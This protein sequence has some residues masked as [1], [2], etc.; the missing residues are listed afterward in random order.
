[1]ILAVDTATRWTGL[2]L[3]SG[4][5]VV[6]EHCWQSVNTQTVE[7]APAVQ[8]MLR[9]AG[10]AVDDLK[11]VA[12]ALGPGSYTGLRIGLGFAKG[13]ALAHQMPLMGV[14]TLDI[15]AAAQPPS[16]GSLV[17]VAEAGRTRITGGR[18]L[19][20]GKQ[21]WQA[22]GSPVNETWE[23]MLRRVETPVTFAGE[24][25][26][27]ALRMIRAAGKGHNV[28]SPAARV[29][30]PGFLAEIGWHRL[31]RGETDDPAV[32]TPLYLREP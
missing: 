6:A 24:L 22:D 5:D 8:Q 21:G 31:R 3:H 29:R 19:W 4:A 13:L 32:L 26:E 2:A 25:S 7:V 12:V 1:M 15:V 20:Q 23:G 28:V 14:P 16:E 10:I 11:G 17:V 9:R 18:Y 27:R 30:R